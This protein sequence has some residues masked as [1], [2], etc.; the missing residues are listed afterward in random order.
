MKLISRIAAFAAALIIALSCTLAAFAADDDFVY[1][2]TS[3]KVLGNYVTV[4]NED[5]EAFYKS[6]DVGMYFYITDSLNISADKAAEN[7]CGEYCS[8]KNAV[9]LVVANSDAGVFLK[10][11]IPG[12]I[13]KDGCIDAYKK[14]SDPV[15]GVKTYF[16]YA[17]GK[18][19]ASGS[20]S[21]AASTPKATGIVTDAA[22]LLTESEVSVLE[23]KLNT[24][25][26]KHSMDIAVVTTLTLNGKTPEEYADDFYDYNGFGRGTARDGVIMLVSME[27]NDIWIST[28]GYGITAFTDAGIDYIYRSVKDDLHN[29]NY[30][31]AF[32]TYADMADDFITKARDGSPVDRKDIP[33][34]A[35]WGKWLGI[36]AVIAVIGSIIVSSTLK[37]SMKSVHSKP[38]A[39]EYVREGSFRI[40]R[41]FD[42]F[43]YSTVTRVYDP[44]S[45]SSS[46]G[47]G[48]STHTS[49][50]GTT[51]GGGG[52][53]F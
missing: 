53:K 23:N 5:A 47:G 26:D 37:A 14:G 25:S 38:Y 7:Y 18:Y 43:L 15:R 45:E 44:P 22:G 36:S 17:Q 19:A 30:M 34:E 48:S 6:F 40:D 2:E 39:S 21:A 13:T 11:D 41:Q 10:G 52:G 35:Q 20:S 9:V 4:L 32:N 49:S 31:S 28:T 29:G 24:L 50:S 33:K 42:N 12:T 27:D 16:A 46:S 8:A 51:H 1:D 3:G